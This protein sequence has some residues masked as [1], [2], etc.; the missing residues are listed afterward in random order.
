MKYKLGKDLPYA[1]M[2]AEVILE[3]DCV[4]IQ[5]RL[6]QK[7]SVRV[8]NDPD[9]YTFRHIGYVENLPQLIIDGWIEE[10]KPREFGVTIYHGKI[11]STGGVPY[12]DK[13]EVLKV[14]EVIE[15]TE[16]YY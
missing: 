3:G 1:K 16:K 11:I 13:K 14:R 9:Y 2:G 10:V 6:K 4:I 7:L 8:D 15:W 12:T 5:E